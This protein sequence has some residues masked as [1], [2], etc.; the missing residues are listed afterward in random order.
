MGSSRVL[1]NLSLLKTR[2][3]ASCQ[4]SRH[5]DES[6]RAKT[7]YNGKEATFLLYLRFVLTS[8]SP[9]PRQSI[10]K[11]AKEVGLWEPPGKEARAALS[12]SRPSDIFRH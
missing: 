6:N 2:S 1:I 12:V 5:Q 7:G 9:S 10:N 4:E 3:S 11:Y 8:I